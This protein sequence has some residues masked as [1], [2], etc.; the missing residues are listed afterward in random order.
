MASKG[1]CLACD[2]PDRDAITTAIAEGSKTLKSLSIQYGIGVQVMTRHLGH[3]MRGG[4]L[5][6]RDRP[7]GET[8]QGGDESRRGASSFRRDRPTGDFA[9]RVHAGIS[10]MLSGATLV[11]E[12]AA[13]R[14]RANSLCV[15]AEASG[16]AR[17]ALLA[18]RELTR[19][20][21]LQGRLALDAASGRAQDVSSH[22]VWLGLAG[23]IMSEIEPCARCK[24]LVSEAIRARLGL[25][26]LPTGG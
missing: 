3:G 23:L 22:P 1:A 18:I 6:R 25:A 4:N 20:L 14:R 24:P 2:H 19:L 16:D 8:A 26:G 21:E 11:S 15:Q 17:T 12:V 5:I 9:G 13:L 7:T 10:A